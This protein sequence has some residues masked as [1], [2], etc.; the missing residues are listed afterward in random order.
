M[1][2][3]LLFI[4][5]FAV[6]ICQLGVLIIMSDVESYAQSWK[7]YPYIKP[8]SKIEFPRDEGFHPDESSEWWYANGHLTGAVTGHQYSFMLAYFHKPVAVF[9]GF[10]ILKITDETTHESY[11]QTLPCIYQILSTD[12]LHI[13]A[14][15]LTADSTEEW[16]NQVDNQSVMLPFQYLIR[17]FT[18]DASVHLSL[19]AKKPPLLIDEDGFLYQGSGNYTYYYSLTSLAANGMIVFGEVKEN[20]TGISWIDRQYGN[21]DPYEDESY[22]W[23]SIRL[24]ENIDLNIWNIFTPDNSIPDSKEYRICSVII[25]DTVSFTTHD[26]QIERL[27]YAFTPDSQRCYATSW[28]LISD[29]I[30]MDLLIEVNDENNEINIK[31]I[32]LRFFEGS[33]RINGTIHDEVITGEGFT[34]LVHSYENPIL[35]FKQPG[36]NE[37]WNYQNPLIWNISNPDEGNPLN[38]DIEIKYQSKLP[39]KIARGLT[40]T[41]FYWNP[42][43]FGHDS[44]INVKINAYSY[45]TTLSDTVIRTFLLE[46]ANTD[47]FACTGESL[48]INLHLDNND[49]LFKWFYNGQISGFTEISA[50]EIDPVTLEAEGIYRCLVYNEFFEDTTVEYH[51]DVGICSQIEN[52]PAA[53]IIIYPNPFK[54]YLSIQLPVK[55]KKYMLRITNLQG[56]IV[57]KAVLGN[58]HEET[59]HPSILPGVYIL[60]IVSWKGEELWIFKIIK[61]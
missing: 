1:N 4:N 48:C 20:V 19:D 36:V 2:K 17:A 25:D 41:L 10:R 7:K 58:I 27:S 26:F 51:L 32:G 47:L 23:F 37:K 30:D 3:I 60:S 9:D 28:S 39:K 40:D 13:L 35:H 14:S 56:A 8:G 61:S 34:E 11:S 5:S 55:N 15:F 29:T 16:V 42:A 12:S 44:V 49:L 38:F 54:D 31:E 43:V 53:G 46:S 18:D 45:D 6:F 21:F 52:N 50:L 33:I 22:E 59:I 57:Y 24:K